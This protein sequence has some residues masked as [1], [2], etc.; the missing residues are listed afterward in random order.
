[1]RTTAPPPWRLRADRSTIASSKPITSVHTGLKRFSTT[2]FVASVVDTDTRLTASRLAPAGPS[3][4]ARIALPMPIARFHGVVSAL[5]LAIT[6]RPSA[7][8]TASVNVP[9]VSIPNDRPPADAADFEFMRTFYT[10][11]PQ[12]LDDGALLQRLIQHLGQADAGFTQ[13]LGRDRGRVGHVG[14]GALVVIG[15]VGCRQ[16]AVGV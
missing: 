7:S 4:A 6:R 14:L 9:P 3:S 11:D 1:M 12:S 5:A 10:V 16:Q 15:P 2:A 8:S 13:L